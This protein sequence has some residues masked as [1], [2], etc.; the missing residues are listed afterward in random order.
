MHPPG[1]APVGVL[2]A[3]IK[4]SFFLNIFEIGICFTS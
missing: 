2:N 3:K 1:S 4:T